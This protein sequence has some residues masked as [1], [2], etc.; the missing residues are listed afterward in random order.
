MRNRNHLLL[1][2]LLSSLLILTSVPLFGQ[3]GSRPSGV[4]TSPRMDADGNKIFDDLDGRMKEKPETAQLPVIVLFN[5]VLDE[6]G[7]SNLKKKVGDFSPEHKY[8]T[9]PG[10]A[11]TLTKGQIIALSKQDEVLQI[12]YDKEMQTFLDT[13][14]LWFGVQKARTDFGVT[15]DRTGAEKTYTKDDIVIAIVDTGIDI[16]H[17]DLDDGKVIGWKDFTGPQKADPYDNNGHGTHVASIAAGEG[18]GNSVYKGVAPGAA[19][20]GVKVLGPSGIGSTSDVNAGIQWVIDNKGTFGIEI[21]SLSLGTAGSSDGTDSTSLLTNTA[22]DNGIVT[23]LAAGNEGPA[24]YTIGSPAAAAKPITVGAMADVGKNGFY[25]AYFSSRGPTADGRIKP[26]ISSPGVSIMAAKYKTTSDYI[27]YSG[28][29]MSTPF[30][31]GV[32]ALMLDANPA[33]IPLQIKNTIMA[34]ALDWGPTGADIDYG[35]GRLDAYEAVKN[36]GSFVGTGPTM[37]NHQYYADSLS[38]TNTA[39]WWDIN[40]TDAFYPIAITMI[41]PAWSGGSPDFDM[42]LYNPSGT[43]VASSLGTTRQ[44]TI[45]YKP[46]VTGTYRLKIYIYSGSGNYFF[47]LSAWTTPGP[48][49]SLTTD[50]TVPFGVVALGATVDSSGDVQ[51]VRV[52]TGPA[53]LSIKTTVYSDGTNNWLLGTT[54][55]PNQVKWEF[56]PTGSGWNTFLAA[57]TYTLAT[58]V[59]TDSTQNVY[60]Q[61]T[62]P[63]ATV[64]SSQHGAIVTIV[65]TSP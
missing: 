54:N 50:G 26:D 32:A 15:G 13:A 64:S 9:V 52:D 34:T 45:A 2:I 11:A 49:I 6:E 38:A 55:G 7:Y 65:A 5:N 48:S 37:P 36:A 53:N 30:T 44:E 58:N 10:M 1:A 47:D 59:A 12:E 3:A 14:T 62:M 27:A 29:S 25:Q 46:T 41:M 33:L 56:S 63:T 40:V 57:N 43:E 28:T 61:L 19:L 23:T 21:M 60:F 39:D 8:T 51:T 16:S 31:A 22:V 35:A 24:K 18:D 17:V 42:R 20:V 4:R